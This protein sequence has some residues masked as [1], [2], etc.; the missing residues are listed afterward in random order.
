MEEALNLKFRTDCTVQCTHMFAGNRK[1][2]D[3]FECAPNIDHTQV[4]ARVR[5]RVCTRA[6]CAPG[7]RRLCGSSVCA[8][9]RGECRLGVCGRAA[10]RVLMGRCMR[11][12][13]P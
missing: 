9:Q 3:E 4:R 5:G 13:V 12:R 2:G 10:S 8:Q 11:L 6:A 7:G 1:L